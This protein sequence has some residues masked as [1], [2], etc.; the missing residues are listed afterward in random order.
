M[1]E[2]EAKGKI[3]N[4]A[5]AFI[6]IRDIL[7]IMDVFALILFSKILH[8][9]IILIPDFGGGGTPLNVAP[10]E[11]AYSPHSSPGPA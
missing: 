8:K 6:Y 11:S 9:N 4:T 7:F 10:K 5:P 2:P 1:W 3:R